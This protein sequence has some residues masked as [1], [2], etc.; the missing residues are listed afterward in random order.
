[1]FIQNEQISWPELDEDP[2]ELF[3][4]A[5]QH[6]EIVDRLTGPIGLWRA[7]QVPGE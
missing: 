3:N 1:M 5:D 6:P 4:R 2:D 7:E